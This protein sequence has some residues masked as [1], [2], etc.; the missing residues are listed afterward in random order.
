MSKSAVGRKKYTIFGNHNGMARRLKHNLG[1]HPYKLQIVQEWKETNFARW[2]DFCEQF[3]HL[4]LL[5][6][7][8]LL[9]F[10]F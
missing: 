2:K 8:E 3:L 9:F 6:D 7:M 1:Y 4:Q 5:E 10:F